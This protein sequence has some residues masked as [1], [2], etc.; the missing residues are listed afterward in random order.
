M[1]DDC[2][3]SHHGDSDSIQV[4]DWMW[5]VIEELVFEGAPQHDRLSSLGS[6]AG[7][8]FLEWY[9]MIE[10]GRTGQRCGR[11]IDEGRG[12]MCF[13]KSRR[14]RLS[15]WFVRSRPNMLGLSNCPHFDRGVESEAAEQIVEIP[16]RTSCS[17]PTASR[18]GRQPE[19]HLG[20]G[21]A[22]CWRFQSAPAM[23]ET[24]RRTSHWIVRSGPSWTVWNCRIR[25]RTLSE[26]CVSRLQRRRQLS[27]WSV[28]S[29]E[30]D[31]GIPSPRPR[32]NSGRLFLGRRKTTCVQVEAELLGLV[33]II[34]ECC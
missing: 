14:W 21:S 3:G 33:R 31:L 22:I 23:A 32:S 12:R 2:H 7:L 8:N 28:H 9:P 13:V 20:D 18:A 24:K 25:R 1:R 29:G 26:V 34:K 11:P 15:V 16:L 5:N 17:S 30:F 4:Y 27:D 6:V 10:A 19:D